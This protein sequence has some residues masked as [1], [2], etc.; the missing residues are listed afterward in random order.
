MRWA[1]KLSRTE[2]DE[3][4]CPCKSTCAPTFIYQFQINLLEMKRS[5]N[6]NI[7]LKQFK[8]KPE[9]IVALIEQGDESKL[10]EEKLQALLKLLPEKDEVQASVYI[11]SLSQF[12]NKMSILRCQF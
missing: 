1:T 11:M 7:F 8:M 10:G 2:S 12:I 6:I 9:E 3:Y 4:H 5:M